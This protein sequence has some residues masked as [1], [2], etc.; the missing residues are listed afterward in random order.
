MRRSR[1]RSRYSGSQAHKQYLLSKH[2]HLDV[3]DFL[4]GS[5]RICVSETGPKTGI[6]DVYFVQLKFKL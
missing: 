2:S 5:I 6:P 1:M 4:D 3:G